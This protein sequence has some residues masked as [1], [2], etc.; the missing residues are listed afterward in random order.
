MRPKCKGTWHPWGRF[1]RLFFWEFIQNLPFAAGFLLGLE[2]GQGGQWGLAAA[3]M[4]GGS[5]LGALAIWATEARMVEGHREPLG[6]MLTNVVVI[7]GLM[8]AVAAYLSAGWSAWW[9]DLLL[10]LVGGMGLGVV[11]DLAAGSSVGWTHALAL[12]LGCA[13]GLIGVRVLAACLPLAWNALLITG[14]VT[15]FIVVVDYGPWRVSSQ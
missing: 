2:A 11:Q 10:G 13:L 14:I 5:I 15:V 1:V 8:L 6:M 3:W 7:A 12:G 4:V 9:T